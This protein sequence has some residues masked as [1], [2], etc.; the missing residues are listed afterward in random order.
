MEKLTELSYSDIKA[1]YD[2]LEIRKDIVSKNPEHFEDGEIHNI[3]NKQKIVWQELNTRFN[4][5]QT[6]QCK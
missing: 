5:I 3:L 6:L 1:I 4:N 2:F